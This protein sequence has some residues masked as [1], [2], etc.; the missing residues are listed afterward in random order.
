MA[1]TPVINLELFLK[2]TSSRKNF[3]FIQ[4]Q[5]IDDIIRDLAKQ[6]ADSADY[7]DTM[8]AINEI[9]QHYSL[10]FIGSLSGFFPTNFT[11]KLKDEMIRFLEIEPIRDYYTHGHKLFLPDALMAY[12]NAINN[13]DTKAFYRSTDKGRN[14]P[15]DDDFFNEFLILSMKINR[16]KNI[17][18]FLKIFDFHYSL[19]SKIKIDRSISLFEDPSSIDKHFNDPSTKENYSVGAL[20][21]L[22]LMGELKEL[23]DKAYYM[24]VLQSAIWHFYGYYFEA[25]SL[26]LKDY[27]EKVFDAL[28]KAYKK[29][30][31]RGSKYDFCDDEDSIVDLEMHIESIAKKSKDTIVSLCDYKRHGVALRKVVK[32]HLAREGVPA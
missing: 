7:T 8:I 22:I 5:N 29:S 20:K 1:E 28:P 26:E 23:L 12:C 2:S 25:C 30:E 11:E 31:L 17:N 9:I 27:Y 3:D 16:D 6:D 19:D 32:Y 4:E 13:N 10:I 21:F 24:P 18:D 15:N 14:E